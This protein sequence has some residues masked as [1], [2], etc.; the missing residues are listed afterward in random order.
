MK[1]NCM[2]YVMMGVAFTFDFISAHPEDQTPPTFG[3][4]MTLNNSNEDAKPNSFRQLD[5]TVLVLLTPV[6]KSLCAKIRREGPHRHCI[7]P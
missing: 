2:I 1:K 5:A 4:G 6:S 7:T 3:W